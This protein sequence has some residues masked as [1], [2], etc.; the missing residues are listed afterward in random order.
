[1]EAN[2]VCEKLGLIKPIV[3]QAEYNMIIRKRFEVDLV[4][5]YEKYGL[6]TTIW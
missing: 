3:E 2:E 6:G 1:M 5:L 4:P